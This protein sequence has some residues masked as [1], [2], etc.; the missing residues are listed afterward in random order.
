MDK[1][2]KNYYFITVFQKYDNYG[3]HGIRCWGFFS[4][5]EEAYRTM[6]LNLTDLWETVYNYGV[7][8][9]YKEGISNYTFRRWFYQYDYEKNEYDLITEPEELRHYAGFALG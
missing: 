4:N 5:F 6:R 8:E 3:P 9:E 2:E 1:E 7:I